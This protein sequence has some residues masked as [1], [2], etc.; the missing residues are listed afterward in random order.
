MTVPAS[1]PRMD[2]ATWGL[3]V[4][5]GLLWG[6]S[7]FFARI[8]VA[9]IPPLTLVL[10][11]VAIAAA[12]LHLV[13][14]RTPGFYA[15]LRARA[16]DFAVMGLLN[17]VIPFTLIFLGQIHNGAGLASILNATTPLWTVI[18][19]QA[20][21]ADE[22]I[23]TAKVVG[24]V[25]G[26]AGT[27]ALLGPAALSAGEVP[28][29]AL[30]AGIGGAVSYGFAAIWG[31]RFAGVPPR[32]TATGQLTASTVVMLPIALL[33]DRPFAL[34]A[35]PAGAVAAVVALALVSTAV[36]YILYFR[37]MAKA[38]ATGASLV[39][40]LV[41]P[42]AILLG[43]LFLGERLSMN[44]LAGFALIALGLLSLDNRLAIRRRGNA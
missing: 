16:S 20:L 42:S 15:I 37:I 32:A 28:F 14:R 34:P 33:V 30:M 9:H 17:N 23:S 18:A 44:E 29:W 13:F 4:A 43:V 19:A 6:G 22:R 41:P 3:L 31:K 21:T 38:G 25:L 40:L 5:L 8:A 2:L 36:A 24:C 1:A 27:V 7:F 35:P 12:T 10:G 11:R 26:L 39:T